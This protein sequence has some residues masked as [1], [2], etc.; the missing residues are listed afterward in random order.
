MVSSNPVPEADH[1]S[2]RKTIEMIIFRF[3]LQILAF[4]YLLAF[5]AAEYIT[6]YLSNV[7]GIIFYFSIL[8]CLIMNSVIDHDEARSKL[9][10]ALGLISII[11]IVSLVI[12]TDLF[13]EIYSYAII[14]AIILIVIFPLMRNLKLNFNDIGLNARKPVIQIFVGI[15]GIG[16][17]MIDYFILRPKALNSQLPFSETIFPALGLLVLIGFIE[18]MVFRGIMQK[19]ARIL[20]SWDWIYIVL[21]YSI[22]QINQKSVLHC[23]FAFAVALFYGWIVKKT[24][25]ILGVIISHSLLNISLFLMF[26]HI[27]KL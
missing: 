25:S 6:Y 13:P 27:L 20:L 1:K 17:G 22:M 8:F 9:W 7:V 19:T 15:S 12:P 11:R 3:E 5:A 4:L 16:L 10:T 26:P 18:E 21:I 24:G 23:T 2:K 14:A